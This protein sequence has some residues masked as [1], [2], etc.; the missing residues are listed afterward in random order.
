MVIKGEMETYR[1]R[2]WRQIQREEM[3]KDIERGDG[4]RDR[5][6]GDRDRERRWRQI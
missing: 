6:D 2:R 4:D 5:G 3:E 1:E